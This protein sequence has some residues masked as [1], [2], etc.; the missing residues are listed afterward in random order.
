MNIGSSVFDIITDAL[1][2]KTGDLFVAK[3]LVDPLTIIGLS[4]FKKG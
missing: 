1:L 2:N 4:V 3:G